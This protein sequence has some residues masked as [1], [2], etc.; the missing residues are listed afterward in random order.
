METK[1]EFDGLNALTCSVVV[2]KKRGKAALEL[3]K[4]TS[5]PE[6]MKAILECCFLEL[7]IIIYPKFQDKFRGLI[8]LQEKGIIKNNKG[9]YI[10][11][12]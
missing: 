4:H 11:L 5:K 7:P 1:K 9:K 8:S 3:R 2:I 10:Y 12:I 6:L